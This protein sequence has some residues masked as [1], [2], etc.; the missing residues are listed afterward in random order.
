M[1]HTETRGKYQTLFFIVMAMIYPLLGLSGNTRIHSHSSGTSCY[2]S[3]N[4][5]EVHTTDKFTAVV[6]HEPHY[7]AILRAVPACSLAMVSSLSNLSSIGLCK[8]P[9]LR[10]R[11]RSRTIE[12]VIACAHAQIPLSSLAMMSSLSNLSSIGMC[13][14][15]PLRTRQRS[16]T[17]TSTSVVGYASA[18][19]FAF[20]KKVN[21]VA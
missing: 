21:A 19:P 1:S 2:P 15:P 12:A 13:A 5:S 18:V 8:A 17:A 20:T 3:P 7:H 14:A 6:E 16:R 9:P 11:Q 10:T 4:D